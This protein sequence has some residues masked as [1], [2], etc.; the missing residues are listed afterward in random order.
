MGNVI[1]AKASVDHQLRDVRLTLAQAQH[2]SE[3]WATD[4]RWFLAEV[5]AVATD[6]EQILEER[7]TEL[8]DIRSERAALDH[9]CNDL[10][11]QVK[12]DLFNTIGRTRADSKFKRIFPVG[13]RL[14]TQPGPGSKPHSLRRLV[15]M[16][17]SYRLSGVSQAQ[18]DDI[19]GRLHA[20]ADALAVVNER[21]DPLSAEVKLVRAQMVANAREGQM[22]LSRL[23]KYWRA[24]GLSEVDV[25]RM[26]PDRPLSSKRSGAAAEDT[27]PEE[28]ADAWASQGS[29]DVPD[30]SDDHDEPAV[31]AK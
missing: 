30:Q 22:Q 18:L 2:V 5:D 31:A 8:T 25:H 6:L 14:Y 24:M 12:D 9:A 19:V 28:P 17:N 29:L 21:W 3:E 13:M 23:K 26:I 7:T 27:I 1:S 4:A 15:R 16:L 11:G 10:V 20:A